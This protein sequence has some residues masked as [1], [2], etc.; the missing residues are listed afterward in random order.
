MHGWLLS[1]RQLIIS[2]LMLIACAKCFLMMLA[3]YGPWMLLSRESLRYQSIEEISVLK[4]GFF[5]KA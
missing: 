5:L 3:M 4:L 2:R 1:K